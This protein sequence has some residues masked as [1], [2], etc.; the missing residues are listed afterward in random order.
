MQ[1]RA[2]R[3]GLRDVR[4]KILHRE[5]ADGTRL[6]SVQLGQAIAIKVGGRFP[7]ITRQLTGLAHKAVAPEARC[8]NPI[9]MRPD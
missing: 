5:A 6:A 9:V 4:A 7:D 1:D 3:P 8:D 2:G